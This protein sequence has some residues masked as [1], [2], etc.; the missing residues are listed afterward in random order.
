[1]SLWGKTGVRCRVVVATQ[2]AGE[3]KS[4]SGHTCKG[5]VDERFFSHLPQEAVT[6]SDGVALAPAIVGL[7]PRCLP[8]K[9]KSRDPDRWCSQAPAGQEA[10]QL[11]WQWVWS[12]R[13]QL[14]HGLEPTLM[15]TTQF[16]P[17]IKETPAEQ[18]PVQGSGKQIARPALES[19][20]FLR[21]GLR[22]RRRRGAVLSGW[23]DGPSNR[24]AK[25][26]CWPSA[27]AL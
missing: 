21:A 17:A 15:R 6:A 11:V 18:P 26:C 8:L 1:M 12:L 9:T 27:R 16:A 7:T 5:V 19:G 10:W 20:P 23:Q 22:P 3:K 13:L 14:G 4:R 2:P 24:A 25:L